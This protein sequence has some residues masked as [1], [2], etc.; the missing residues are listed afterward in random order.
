M[1]GPSPSG[2]WGC[3]GPG[4]CP[5]IAGH[6]SRGYDAASV[7]PS[8]LSGHGRTP[9]DRLHRGRVDAAFPPPA[10]AASG[11]AERD[12]DRARRHRLRASGL[13]RLRHRDAAH[14]R[15]RRGGCAVQPLP[16]HLA[17]LADTG[18]V[19]HGAQPPRRRNGI[20]GRHPAGLSRL[21]RP[22]A[23]RRPPPSP[24]C[25]ATPG[26]PPWPSA[27]GTSR[28]AGSARPPGP[29]TPG[30]SASASSAT[31][32]SSRATPTTGHRTWSATTTTSSRR[33][34]PRTGTT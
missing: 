22:L 31:T 19:L 18:I 7:R 25:C 9:A 21:P 26:T 11:R 10:Q 32:A 15:A 33:A 2:K 13:V 28:R 8:T 23:A 5:C 14:G 20:P 1:N 3:G 6:V 4:R 27:S 17:L 30:R 16:R 29:S 12:R 34:G 24:A